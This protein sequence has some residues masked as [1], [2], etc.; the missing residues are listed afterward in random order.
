[1]FFLGRSA[2]LKGDDQSVCVSA[3][4]SS[5]G[6]ND[7]DEVDVQP[8]DLGHEIRQGVQSRLAE[9]IIALAMK[10]LEAAAKAFCCCTTFTQLKPA[11]RDRNDDGASFRCGRFPHS[12]R[13]AP[14]KPWTLSPVLGQ[15]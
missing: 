11:L 8:I 3:E 2:F 1:L 6:P 15:R 5:A 12:F 13:R 10:R 14:P 7:M 4:S 9:E